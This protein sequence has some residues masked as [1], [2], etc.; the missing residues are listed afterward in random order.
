LILLD[1]SF[2]FWRPICSSSELT[3]L[4]KIWFLHYRLSRRHNFFFLT[5]FWPQDLTP[6]APTRYAFFSVRAFRR[7]CY[8]SRSPAWVLHP[9]VVPGHLGLPLGF[10]IPLWC[11]VKALIFFE[12]E[13]IAHDFPPVLFFLRRSLTSISHKG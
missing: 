6:S 2:S 3:S 1:L 11:R 5:L 8:A 4:V 10:F 9:A 7:C 13:R 12:Q